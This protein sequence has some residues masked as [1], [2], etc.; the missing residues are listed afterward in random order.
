MRLSELI[1]RDTIISPLSATRRYDAIAEALECLI[2]HGHVPEGLRD[3]ALAALHHR[4]R[5]LSTGIGHGVAVPHAQ[6]EGL[7]APVAALAISRDGIEFETA[8]GKPAQLIILVLTPVSRPARRIATL[9][10]IARLFKR[11]DLRD[12]LLTAE[13]AADVIDVIER[14]EAEPDR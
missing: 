8:D 3:P 13:K 1:Q 10:A 4:E 2:A 9:A 12:A 14:A 11:A 6:V 5:Q 7:P